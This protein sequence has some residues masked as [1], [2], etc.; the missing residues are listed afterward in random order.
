MINMNWLQTKL[1][2][3]Q[4][5][6]QNYKPNR[7]IQIL[8]KWLPNQIRSNFNSSTSLPIFLIT[9]KKKYINLIANTPN[10]LIII[11]NNLQKRKFKLLNRQQDQYPRL[12]MKFQQNLMKNLYT[13]YNR[14][15]Q[16][17][18]KYGKYCILLNKICKLYRRIDKE[19]KL[20]LHNHP[21]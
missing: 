10:T 15:P 3:I 5:C 7:Y 14:L 12:K 11:C 6:N 13:D 4:L 20:I 2:I 17:I 21:D 8:T 9:N 18:K 1:R 19:T 16:I